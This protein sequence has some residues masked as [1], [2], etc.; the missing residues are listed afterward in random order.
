VDLDELPLGR[1]ATSDFSCSRVL[2]RMMM[3]ER[4]IENSL[5]KTLRELERR[6]LI[7]QFQQQDVE[8]QFEPE[9]AI[10]KACGFEAATRTPLDKNSDLKK[11]SQFEPAIIGVTPYMKGDYDNIP[12]CS[13]QRKQSQTNPIP[14]SPQHCCRVQN[15]I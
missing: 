4:R 13:A 6:Q 7:R 8:Q 5:N 10:P 3:Y 2:D 11:Q 9:Q 12:P 15:G 1:I 14:F